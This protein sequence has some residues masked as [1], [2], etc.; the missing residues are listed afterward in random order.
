MSQPYMKS[1]RHTYICTIHLWGVCGGGRRRRRRR[2]LYEFDN[3]LH[4]NIFLPCRSQG[5]EVKK[6]KVW[7]ATVAPVAVLLIDC[8]KSC[9][10]TSILVVRVATVRSKMV[11]NDGD[12]LRPVD[13][14][15]GEWGSHPL[16]RR[17]RSFACSMDGGGRGFFSFFSS[18]FQ[19]KP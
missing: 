17:S 1:C 13:L 2:S 16:R 19:P 6:K 8:G 10:I 11:V 9:S 3:F 15:P 4:F 5:N 18:G 14:L 7:K 12:R